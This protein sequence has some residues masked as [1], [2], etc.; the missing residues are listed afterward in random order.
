MMLAVLG[1]LA[2]FER[3][4]IRARTGEGGERAEARGVHMGSPPMLTAHQKAEAL[5][6]FSIRPTID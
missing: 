2:E 3:E 4:V 5:K 1:G 6:P